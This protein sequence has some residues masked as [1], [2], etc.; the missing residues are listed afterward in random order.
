MKHRYLLP[1]A[2]AAAPTSAAAHSF[3]S[4]AD[5]Y[6]QFVEGAGVIATYPAV[7]LPLLA[8]GLFLTLWQS[9]G[10]VAAW[11]YFLAGQIAG[12]AVAPLVGEWILPVMMSAGIIVGALAALLPQPN[13]PLSLIFAATLGTLTLALGLE[14]HRFFELPVLIHLGLLFGANAAVA[15]AAGIA[16]LALEKVPAEWMRITVRV[17]ASWIAAMLMLILAFTLR[18]GGVT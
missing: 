4:G 16:R 13:R 15:L 7:F 8:L 14:G 1:L 3:E 17:A 2:F 5:L 10:M 11:P 9:E 6:A 12:I 18:G